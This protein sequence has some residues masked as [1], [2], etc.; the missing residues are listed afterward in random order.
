MSPHGAHQGSLDCDGVSQQNETVQPPQW[1]PNRRWHH[2]TEPAWKMLQLIP[3]QGTG[4]GLLGTGTLGQRVLGIPYILGF[5]SAPCP[6]VPKVPTKK[7]VTLTPS[8]CFPPCS[9]PQR[10]LVMWRNPKPPG[11]WRM[12]SGG[13]AGMPQQYS[14]RSSYHRASGTPST[15]KTPQQPLHTLQQPRACKRPSSSSPSSTPATKTQRLAGGDHSQGCN[16]TYCARCYRLCFS[17]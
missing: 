1:Q 5:P 16:R 17:H 10:A 3:C 12:G 7:E 15:T 11:I 2:G 8:P 4:R 9:P 13:W 14:A 6:Q